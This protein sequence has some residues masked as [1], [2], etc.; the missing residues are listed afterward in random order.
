MY[1]KVYEDYKT[2]LTTYPNHETAKD[3]LQGL[4]DL[5]KYITPEKLSN[6]LSLYKN[7]DPSNS[8][9]EKIEFDL[10][11]S[12]FFDQQYGSVHDN[13]KTF[14]KNHPQSQYLQDVFFYDRQILLCRSTREDRLSSRWELSWW[15]FARP[16]FRYIM[17]T[18]NSGVGT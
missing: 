16:L 9:L 5:R 12:A 17:G 8:N 18:R 11:K 4:Q 3:V 7:T 15:A 14:I 6:L 2:I 13:A 1:T 10:V